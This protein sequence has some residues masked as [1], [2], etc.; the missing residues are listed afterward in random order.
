[1][2]SKPRGSRWPVP[3][4]FALCGLMLD[5]AALAAGDVGYALF[6]LAL[7]SVLATAAVRRGL[8]TQLTLCSWIGSS[9]SSGLWSGRRL[10]REELGLPPGTSNATGS[11][12]SQSVPSPANP[13]TSPSPSTARPPSPT[14]HPE[15]ARSSS[16]HRRLDRR[17]VRCSIRRSA[18]AAGPNR[19]LLRS[20]TSIGRRQQEKQAPR[21]G[22]CPLEQLG[23]EW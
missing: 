22:H 13:T 17:G 3:A 5:A 21:A 4:T 11:R 10:R 12:S 20:S 8:G 23:Q 16:A 9:S 7:F 2:R 15:T 14:R 19:W 6:S 18:E 1:M